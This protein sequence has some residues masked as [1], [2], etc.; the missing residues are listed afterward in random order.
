MF[1]RKH[2]NKDTLFS[3]ELENKIMKPDY[4]KILN[5]AYQQFILDVEGKKVAIPYRINI[6]PVEHPARQGKSSPEV[7]LNQLK[8]DAE[9]EGFDLKTATVE[10]IRQFMEDHKL[11]IDCSGFA[12][13]MI[14]ILCEELGM[15]NLQENGFDHVGR[16]NVNALT[17]PEHAIR[18]DGFKSAHPGD[19]IKLVGNDPTPHILLVIEV[20]DQGIL[21]AHSSDGTEIKGVHMERIIKDEFQEKLTFSVEGIYRLKVLD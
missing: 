12:Y 8:E 11:G 9:N 19:L 4:S 13:R 14:E 3:H 6:P 15:G 10:E 16:T 2:E 1:S 21:Y 5:K 20:R 7:I 17:S 18:I